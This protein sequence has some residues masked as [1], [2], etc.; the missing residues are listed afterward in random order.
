MLIASR[1]TKQKIIISS[2]DLE[3][4][5]EIS[6]LGITEGVVRLGIEA[7][8]SVKVDREE[9][10]NLKNESNKQGAF[11]GNTREDS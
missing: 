4:K 1:R 7:P 6:V 3:G 2:K 8:K 9:I 11:N 10:F 5:I